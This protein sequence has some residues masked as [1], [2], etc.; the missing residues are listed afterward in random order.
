MPFYTFTQNNSGGSFIFDGEAGISHYVIVEAEDHSDANR[1]AE[2]IGLYFHGAGDCPCCG[3]RWCEAWQGEGD[4]SPEVY[5]EPVETAS[6]LTKWM[7]HNPEVFVHY[8]DGR[9]VPY[10]GGQDAA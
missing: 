9:I 3:N 4:Q 1:K 5:G 8:T 2:E 7:A 10:H 6:F